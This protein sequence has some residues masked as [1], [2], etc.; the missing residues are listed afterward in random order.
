VTDVRTPKQERSQRRRDALLRAA[1]ELISESGPQAV[2]HRAV[3][4]RA[5]VP[6]ST[7]GYF[8]ASIDDLS[9]E[10]LRLHTAQSA[11]EFRAL[12]QAAAQ[13][14]RR[15]ADKL[16][17]AI[18]QHRDDTEQALAQVA[19]YLDASR[20]PA[21]RGPVAEAFETYRELTETLLTNDGMPRARA[22]ASGFVA[23]LDGFM[24]HTLAKPDDPPSAKVIA[25]ALNAL[26]AGY[27][28]DADERRAVKARVQPTTTAGRPGAAKVR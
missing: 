17:E 11:A 19:M 1:V 23:L 24:L 28:L 25:D 2:T 10:A 12:G 15:S 16:I 13:G 8:F 22:A 7:A 3:A 6:A 5:G 27:L 14:R 21:M 9:A 18:A 26:M 4:A 20:N